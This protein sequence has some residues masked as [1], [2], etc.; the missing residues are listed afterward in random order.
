MEN[1]IEGRKH[2][3]TFNQLEK[4]VLEKCLELGDAIAKHGKE[5]LVATEKH[6]KIF[7]MNKV[8]ESILASMLNISSQLVYLSSNPQMLAVHRGGGDITPEKDF[9][10]KRCEDGEIQVWQ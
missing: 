5:V 4:D 10:F 8:H 6:G 2:I 7:G 1:I 9:L 3:A